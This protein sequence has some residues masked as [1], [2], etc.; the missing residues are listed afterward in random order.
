MIGSISLASNLRSKYLPQC[1]WSNAS[2]LLRRAMQAWYMIASWKAGLSPHR[3][4][5]Q[6]LLMYRLVSSPNWQHHL[7]LEEVWEPAIIKTIG[8]YQSGVMFSKLDRWFEMIAYTGDSRPRSRSPSNAEGSCQDRPLHLII[9]ILIAQ[10]WIDKL[11]NFSFL[12]DILCLPS[13]FINQLF[14]SLILRYKHNYGE[15]LW[16]SYP[17]DKAL[18]VIRR[19]SDDRLPT[20]EQLQKHNSESINVYF[21][22]DLSVH[23]ILG[24]KVPVDGEKFSWAIEREWHFQLTRIWNR[25]KPKCP[26]DIAA[27][28]GFGWL[29]C[30]LCETEIWQLKYDNNQI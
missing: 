18:L 27:C 10:R 17:N 11:L 12:H 5:H 7:R 20:R 23:E 2:H 3:L 19:A 13:T 4:N 26:R 21:F 30:P 16:R 8:K 25:Y 29:W 9:V 22:R 24:S 6:T 1:C 15:N 28:Y 14:S